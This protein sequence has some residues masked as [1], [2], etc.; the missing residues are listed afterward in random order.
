M[1]SYK[2]GKM[3]VAQLARGTHDVEGDGMWSSMT[4]TLYVC[5]LAIG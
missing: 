3:I 2:L 4:T 1:A 5:V